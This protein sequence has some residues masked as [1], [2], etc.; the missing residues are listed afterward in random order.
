MSASNAALDQMKSLLRSKG[1]EEEFL[2][3]SGL[4]SLD[5]LSPRNFR[6]LD[7]QSTT[8]VSRPTNDP[9]PKPAPEL[10]KSSA[11]AAAT[12]TPEHASDMLEPFLTSRVVYASRKKLS[13]YMPTATMLYYVVHLINC[14]LV[15]NF[16]FK[17]NCPDYH[18]YVLRLYFGIIF[19]IQIFRACLD[20]KVLDPDASEFLTRFLNAFPAEKLPIPGPLVALFKTICNSQP[21]IQSYGKIHPS[22]PAQPGQ[23]R[24]E[25][26]LPNTATILA[27][28]QIPQIFALLADLNAKINA[29]TPIYPKKGK[30]QVQDDMST[31][32]IFGTHTYAAA[33]DRTDIDKWSLSCCGLEFPCEA[34]AKLN[35]AFAERYENFDFPTLAAAD[36]LSDYWG[37]LHFRRNFAWFSQV[38]DVAEVASMYFNGSGSLADCSPSGIVSNQFSVQYESTETVLPAPTKLADPASRFHLAFRLT[39]TARS[40]PALAETMAA[41][42]QTHARFPPNHPFARSI[43]KEATRKGS[44]WDIR[45][46]EKSQVDDS[47]YMSLSDIV[48]KMMKAKV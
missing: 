18:P 34:D 35:E 27:V 36:D 37:F 31:Q 11:D 5:E 42:A 47:A 45:P 4:D 22:Y 28:P 33:A 6:E 1:L 29:N 16:Y 25:N 38:R 41:M 30:H 20:A 8:Q 12:S 43:G 46:V 14:H 23:A 21:E 40:P 15:D 13:N 3:S 17:R 19:Y 26:S 44:F 9:A 7:S 2:K 32:F 48:K 39:T 10:K 24:R